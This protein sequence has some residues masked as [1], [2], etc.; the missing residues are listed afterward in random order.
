MWTKL[1]ST[2]ERKQALFDLWDEI[3]ETGPDDVVAAGIAARAQI[4]GFVRARLT[5]A[6]A[7][8]ATELERL[9]GAKKSTATFDPYRE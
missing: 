6:D 8:T 7:Y 9:N 1:T 2:A 5:G 4:I 3:A